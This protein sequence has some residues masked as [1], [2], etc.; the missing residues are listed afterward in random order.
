MF[1]P[2]EF[3]I[4]DGYNIIHAWPDLKKIADLSLE[5]ARN[6]LLDRLSN[7]QG[8]K[9]FTVLVVFD[10]YLVKGSPGSSAKYNNIYVVY[11]KE[12]ETADRYIERIVHKLPKDIFIRVATSDALEQIIVMGRGAVRM[13]ALELRKEI[14]ETEKAIRE[15]YIENR[16]IKNNLLSDNLD[17]G[18]LEWLENM[19][20]RRNFKE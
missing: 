13:S 6:S 4:V 7:F 20:R 2:K 5:E 11:T 8:F 15:N 3:L 9:Q 18:T 12:A 19:R 10:G 14:L 17:K 16:P 1:E